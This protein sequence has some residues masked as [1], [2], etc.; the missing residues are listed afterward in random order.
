MNGD[1]NKSGLSEAMETGARIANSAR[2]ANAIKGAIKTGKAIAGAAKGAAAGPYGAAAGFLW[3]NRKTAAKIIA[4]SAF[5][6]ML[7]VLYI[8]MLPS[9][10]FGGLEVETETPVMNDDTA[11]YANISEA[12]SVVSAA[13]QEAHD[14]VVDKI[15]GEISG[16]SKNAAGNIIDDYINGAPFNNFMLISQYS[17]SKNY[18]EINLKD[19][20]KVIESKKNGLFSYTMA[21]SSAKDEDGEVHTT[22]TYTVVYEGEAVFTEAFGLDGDSLNLAFD[23]S[24]NLSAYIYGAPS[25]LPGANVSAEVS[26]HAGAI[27]K[28]AEKYGIKGFIDVI[29]AVMMQESG[30][31][32]G[33]PMQCSE[34]PYNEKYPKTPN[35][36]TDPD[37]SIETGI[38]YLA[39][40]LSDA[41][42]T[43]PADV[44]KL[45]LALQGYNYGGGY[46][47]W[48]K[49]NYGGYTAANAKEFSEKKKRELGWKGY[50]DP[51]YVT[52][53]MRYLR[54]ISVEGGEDGWGNPFPGTDWRTRVTSEFS[55]RKD[56]FTGETK[57]HDGIDFGYPGGTLIYPVK[58]GVVKT[59]VY[60]STGYG[61][62]LII[63]HGGG[64]E[65]LYGH[66]SAILVS[67]GQAVTTSAPIA[68][69]GST[70]KS[71]G[72]H[73]HLEI[74]VNGAA[75]NPRIYLN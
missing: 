7:P 50:G 62:H 71:T 52:H 35:G 30:G 42:C 17:A 1:N 14:A 16:L 28:Y 10:V 66:C 45:S 4:A 37:Y 26:A 74:R 44:A 64:F 67:V 59:V 12:E 60:G 39:G 6:L 41:G 29:C 72:N 19:F 69:V 23:Y 53:V 22:V 25:F 58:P 65:S 36:I 21:A 5:L 57:I 40:C 55:T 13:L 46:I 48:A 75:V 56:P 33:D 38:K 2:T 43:S 18:A 3:E 63:D 11:I 15:N 73:L 34:C 9:L 32:G 8:M 27:A 51:E 61:Y 20:K 49:S 47:G 31:R 68:K 70:G 54:A 24:E